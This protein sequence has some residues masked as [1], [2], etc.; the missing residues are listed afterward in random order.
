MMKMLDEVRVTI[1]AGEGSTPPVPLWLI[2]TSDGDIEARDEL[3]Q[4]HAK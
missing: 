2:V 3:N 4:Q 1:E